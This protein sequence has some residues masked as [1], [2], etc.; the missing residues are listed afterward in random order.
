MFK[1]LW[2]SSW[3]FLNTKI[4]VGETIQ[5]GVDTTKAVLDLS[6]AIDDNKTLSELTPLIGHLSSIL[7]VLNLPIVQLA[8]SALPF[9]SIA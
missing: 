7:D 6:K 4:S 9:V 8:G 2:Q 5:G 3:E 1:G